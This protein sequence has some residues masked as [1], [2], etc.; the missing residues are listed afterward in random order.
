MKESD[1]LAG[2]T[3]NISLRKEIL[4]NTKVKYRKESNALAGNADKNS[5][6]KENIAKHKR[7]VHEGF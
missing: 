5:L 6:I 3:G 4:L 2:N 7:T 1:T